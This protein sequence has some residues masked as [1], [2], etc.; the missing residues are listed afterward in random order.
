M[1][2]MLIAPCGMNCG[3]CVSYLAGKNNLNKKGFKK[4]YCEGCLPRGKNCSFMKDQCDLLGK[5]QVRFCF[6]CMEFPCRRLKNL[7][8]RYRTKYHMSM[9]ENLQF[10]KEHGVDEFLKKEKEKWRCN[11][12][13]GTVCCHNGLCLNC[14]IEKL[15]K[16]KKYRW[17]DEKI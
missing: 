2:E 4:T 15:I 7:D 13:G 1:E 12:C 5:G 3:I 8:K 6:E 17:E 10:I 14:G 16:N 9:I 11:I